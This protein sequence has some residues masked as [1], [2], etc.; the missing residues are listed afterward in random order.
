VKYLYLILRLFF[1]SKKPIFVC[2]HK[3]Q[4][5]NKVAIESAYGDHLVA[6]VIVQKCEKCGTLQQ[7]KIG[8]K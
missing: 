6:Y 1:Q 3:W 7:F 8:K 2:A 4:E 5:F